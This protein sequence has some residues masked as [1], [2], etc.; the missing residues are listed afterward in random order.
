MGQLTLAD[1]RA[2]ASRRRMA[3][4]LQLAAG[5]TTVEQIISD[6]CLP[7]NK[8][9]LKIRLH[10]LLENSPS[11]GPRS[12]RERMARFAR[13]MDLT[14][15]QAK[16]LTIAWLITPQAGG[17]RRE[18]WLDTVVHYGDRPEPYWEGFPWAAP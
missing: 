7:E 16:S 3:Q 17:R 18:L 15:S 13:A 8:A 6:A 1:A 9:L 11:L 10:H 14:G 2:A 4:L 5:Q 12:A